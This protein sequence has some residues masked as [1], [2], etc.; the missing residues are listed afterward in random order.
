MEC[1]REE[2]VIEG[3][4]AWRIASFCVPASPEFPRVLAARL[5]KAK[6]IFAPGLLEEWP[7]AAQRWRSTLAGSNQCGT[8]FTSLSHTLCSTQTRLFPFAQIHLPPQCRGKSMDT[9]DNQ[10]PLLTSCMILGKLF[11]LSEL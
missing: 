3:A 11:N 6:I 10:T 7:L 4:C 5:L 9:R 8:V 1:W 2:R